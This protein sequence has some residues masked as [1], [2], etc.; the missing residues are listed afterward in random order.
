MS[1][2]NSSE[3]LKT[4]G[5]NDPCPCGSGKKYKKCHLLKDEIAEHKKLLLKE[6]ELASIEKPKNEKEDESDNKKG[7]KEKFS[8]YKAVSKP[9]M[10]KSNKPSNIPRRSAI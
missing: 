2:L 4:I 5:R 10:N 9:K 8:I 7:K 3:R 6:E 1:K